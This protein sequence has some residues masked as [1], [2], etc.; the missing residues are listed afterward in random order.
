VTFSGSDGMNNGSWRQKDKLIVYKSEI[1]E[2]GILQFEANLK[3][4]IKMCE[5][6]KVPIV[7]GTLASNLKDQ[8]PF[9]SVSENNYPSAEKIYLD[10]QIALSQG[11]SDSALNKFVYA[12]D[13]DGLRFRAP[14]KINEVINSLGKQFGC[15][16]VDVFKEFNNSS[17]DKIVGSNLMTD[18]LHPTFEGYKLI[19]ELYFREMERNKLLPEYGKA[20]MTETE[21]NRL[22]ES[23]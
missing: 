20:Q 5:D 23:R 22:L 1:F 14:Q 12:K 16:I 19:G 15:P 17:P 11:Q 21:I 13:L 6:V 4:I 3:D 18:H 10:A 9:V 7:L 2:D 8:K